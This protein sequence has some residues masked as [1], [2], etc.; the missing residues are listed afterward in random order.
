MKKIPL[1]QGQF[2]MIDNEDFDLVNRYKWTANKIGN[3]FYAITG[4]W[5]RELKKQTPIRMHRL[6]MKV[7]D[8]SIFIDHIDH[9]GLNNCKYNLREATRLQ[10]QLNSP[11]RKNKNSKYKGV[12]WCKCARAWRVKIRHNQK[13]KM[14]GTF[15]NEVEAAIKYN[16]VAFKMYGEFAYLNIV[17]C[18]D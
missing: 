18:G 2:A 14:C 7:Y 9:N 13:N 11:P 8:S 16:E 6:V 5:D 4:A 17:S 12:Y 15:H 3:T 10:N 1:T